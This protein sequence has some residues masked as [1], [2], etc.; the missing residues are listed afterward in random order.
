MPSFL[1]MTCSRGLLLISISGQT[2]HRLYYQQQL[3]EPHYVAAG[4]GG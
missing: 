3:Q 2:L 1:S 4:L